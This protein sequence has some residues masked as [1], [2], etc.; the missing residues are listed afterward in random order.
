MNKEITKVLDNNEYIK[1]VIEEIDNYLIADFEILKTTYEDTPLLIHPIAKAYSIINKYRFNK[2]EIPENKI[3]P[4]ISILLKRDKILEIIDNIIMM[5]YEIESNNIHEYNKV[6]AQT[7]IKL[8]EKYSK[9]GDIVKFFSKKHNKDILLDNTNNAKRNYKESYNLRGNYMKNKE[10]NINTTTNTDIN[11]N[12]STTYPNR[13]TRPITADE[14]KRIYNPLVVEA[15]KDIVNKKQN[16]LF[17]NWLEYR[18]YILQYMNSKL[19]TELPLPTYNTEFIMRSTIMKRYLREFGN[20]H[21][22]VYWDDTEGKP[23]NFIKE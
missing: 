1:E 12:S 4:I 23:I 19:S 7:I 22:T 17:K 11:N 14:Y 6:G 5:Y 2:E 18:E 15:I 16:V 9:R 10:N 13:I 21:I 3:T 8:Y 20:S